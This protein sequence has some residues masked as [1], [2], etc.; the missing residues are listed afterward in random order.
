VAI[1]DS[2]DAMTNN[3]VYRKA[4]TSKEAVEE[5]KRNNGTQF[6]PQIVEIFL[7]IIDTYLMRQSEWTH[8]TSAS[9]SVNT[10]EQ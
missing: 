4:M 5:I 1:A 9:E 8:D 3:R 7:N 10:P 6:D 2:Y